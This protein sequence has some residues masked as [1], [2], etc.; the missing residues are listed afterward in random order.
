[1][2]THA[3]THARTGASQGL[4]QGGCAKS[5]VCHAVLEQIK[6]DAANKAGC[7][8]QSRLRPPKQ[9]VRSFV[10]HHLY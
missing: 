6:Q 4:P 2:V 5:R 8:H 7:D 1:M 9:V 10:R 3:R